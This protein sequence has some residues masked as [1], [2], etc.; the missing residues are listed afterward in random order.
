MKETKTESPPHEPSGADALS[1]LLAAAGKQKGKPPVEKWNPPYCGEIGMRIASDGTWFYQG[2]PIGRHALVKLFSSILR[3]DPDGHVLV[4]PVERVGI[5]VEDA[6]FLAVEMV[7]DGEGDAR[8]LSFRT[9]VDDLVEVGPD[10]PLR[11]D[12]DAQG[13]VKPYLL[14]RG[15]LWALVTRP[16]MYDLIEMGEERD[17][18]GRPVF[19]IG[20]GGM[21]HVI[22]SDGSGSHD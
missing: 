12:R 15:D 8:R 20:A 7:A 5:E 22:D 10:H 14:V 4:T 18:S 13:G 21:F 9:N 1:R 11:F 3:K 6:P 16:L 17:V 19:G 2:S